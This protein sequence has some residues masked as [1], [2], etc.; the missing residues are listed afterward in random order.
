MKYLVVCQHCMDVFSFQR[1][2]SAQQRCSQASLIYISN[3]TPSLPC[4]QMEGET[5]KAW[6]QNYQ[7]NTFLSWQGDGGGGLA[8]Q[9]GRPGGGA[10]LRDSAG[11]LKTKRYSIDNTTGIQYRHGL[12]A[13]SW[14]PKAKD[15]LLFY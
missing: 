3:I 14:N 10:P 11:R 13:T 6:K 4:E 8:F 1:L 9:L 12:L 5:R 7:P 15:S 2:S